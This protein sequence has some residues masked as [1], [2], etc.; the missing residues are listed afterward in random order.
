MMQTAGA[1]VT[2][3]D[4]EPA[5][6]AYAARH[7]PGPTYKVGSACEPHGTFDWVVSLETL[8]HLPEPEK[9]LEHYSDSYNL[10][11]STPNAERYLF[12]PKQYAADKYPH[13]RHYTPA[14]LDAMLWSCGWNVVSRHTQRDKTSPVTE[15]T[16]GMFLVYVCN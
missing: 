11:V 3:V 5:A 7:W 8:E 13:L 9:A 12:R 4:L 10:I 14:E 15:G 16:D 1:R 6:V 2:G